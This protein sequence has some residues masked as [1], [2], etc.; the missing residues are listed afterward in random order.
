MSTQ[1]FEKILRESINLDFTTVFSKIFFSIPII[2]QYIV[3]VNTSDHNQEKNKIE[4]YAN[5]CLEKPNNRKI[6]FFTGIL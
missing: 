6:N 3:Y 5:F 4:N 2:P 1:M